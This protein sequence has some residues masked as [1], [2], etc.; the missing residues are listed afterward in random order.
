M[1]NTPE[2]LKEKGFNLRY[3]IVIAL[4][5][6]VVSMVYHYFIFLLLLYIAFSIY[7]YVKSQGEYSKRYNRTL[8]YYKEDNYSECLAAIKD[9]ESKYNLEEN[10]IIIKALCHFNLEEYEDYIKE[11]SK[12]KSKDIN[13]D[14]YIL[15]NKAAS[16]KYLGE[17][18]KALEVYNYLAKAFPN[19]SL[20]KES[21]ME[22]KNQE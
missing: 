17:K 8:N 6:L 14:L 4:I 5:F 10:I 22:I 9:I 19:S 18:Q 12:V 21:I 15:L 2:Y 16:Y 11:I 20:I 1:D 13:N 7:S 3:H